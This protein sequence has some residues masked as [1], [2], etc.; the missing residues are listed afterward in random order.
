MFKI[1]RI[2][3]TAWY[4]LIIMSISI[5][6]SLAIFYILNNEIDD[7]YRRL[8]H[9][10]FDL[11]QQFFSVY[12]PPQLD[13]SAWEE[14]KNRIKLEL[15]YINLVILVVSATAGY[16][17]AGRTLKPIKTMVGEQTRFVADSSH[18]LRTPLTSLMT[19][20]EV[21]LRNKKLNLSQ[22]KA[23]L[24]S[25]LEDVNNLKSMSD[26][27]LILA[28]ADDSIN[29]KNFQLLA[30]PEVVDEAI[31]KVFSLAKKKDIKINQ[32]VE[33]IEIAGSK[34]ELVRL[35]VIF[36][37]NAI[38][39]SKSKS[40]VLIKTFSTDHQIK[41]SIQDF[42]IGISE[43][44]LPYIFDRFFRV[45]KSR[46]ETEGYGLGLAIAQKIIKKY[47]GEIL[48]ESKLNKGTNFTIILPIV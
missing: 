19:S 42:G 45:D 20:I 33:D 10:Y 17:L 31:K 47:K 27:L 13:L 43:E 14:A 2:K 26:D 15:I 37:D 1:A 18:E 44:D 32:K 38:K 39:Y 22:A 5:L 28:R 11:N 6:F 12:P 8:A 36:L 41:I 30:V 34:D 3:L 46:S 24:K 23:L 29:G 16:F 35:L 21:G 48:V 4:L 7:S 25:N 40:Q 9:R